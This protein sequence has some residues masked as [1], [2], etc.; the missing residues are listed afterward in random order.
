MRQRLA[1]TLIE[2]LA[3]ALPP[4]QVYRVAAALSGAFLRGKTKRLLEDT[5]ELFP[6]KPEA[7][8]R[9]AVRRQRHH[10]AWV[11]VDKFMLTRLAGDEVVAMHEPESVAGVRRLADDAFAGGKGVIV[12]TLHYGRPTWSPALFAE[13][14]YPYIGLSRGDT[15]AQQQHTKEVRARGAAVIEAGDLAAGVHALRGLKENRSLFVLIDGRVTQR[16]TVVEFLGRKI[17]VSLGFAQLARRSGA[18]LIAGVTSTGA[19]PTRLR[20]EG[21]LVDLPDGDLSP[22]ELGRHLVAPLERMVV[23]DVGQWYGINRLFRQA[24]RLERDP[25]WD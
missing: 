7:W 9:D 2:V 16:P 13:L 14:G 17:P 3:S 11:A 20:I 10:R 22:E 8:V 5:R 4:R 21:A 25:E 1:R 18:R 24:R 6:D 12:Y 15:D 19:D 23:R